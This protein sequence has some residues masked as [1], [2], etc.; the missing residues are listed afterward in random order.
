MA[1]QIPHIHLA[2]FHSSDENKRKQLIKTLGDG[3]CE[4]G[5]VTVG[6]HGVDPA[7]YQSAYEQFKKLFSMGEEVKRQYDTSADNS[8]GYTP[9][10]KEHAK[11]NPSPDLKEFWQVGQ[12]VDKDDPQA[13]LYFDNVW[14]KECP[15][16]R[17]TTVG[18]YRALERCAKD[19]MEAFALYFELPQ[20]TFSEMVVG[21]DSV[22]RAIHYPP[23]K[24][25]L[26]PNQVRAAAH[27]DI[28]MMT[29]L[30]QS[31]GDGLEIL[32]HENEWLAVNAPAGD[33][34]VDT[35]D[36]MSRI[37]NNVVPATTHRV[38]NPPQAENRARFS[39][40][41]FIH[42]HPQWELKVLD[43]FVTE[44]QPAKYPPIT[45]RAFLQERLREIGLKK[46]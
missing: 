42:P 41:F 28:N 44:E 13:S 33:L 45:A 46:D 43:R 14:P 19:L 6:G 38:I 34:V 32:T 35:G 31:D 30:P 18:L 3:L 15:E 25:E 10:G 7:L 4:F 9:F 24:G 39:M 5:F 27:E 36:M 23:V 29:L 26:Q 1:K 20:E 22:L 17:E 21:G 37:T 16:L 40:P 2:D 11:D 8:R 12:E